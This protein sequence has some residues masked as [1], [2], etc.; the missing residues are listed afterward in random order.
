MKSAF[1]NH[2]KTKFPELYNQPILLACSGGIDSVVLAYLCREAHLDFALA[3]CNFKLR[4][5][6]SAADAI[7]V[8]QL[9]NQL[10]IPFFTTS[11]DTELHAKKQKCSIQM[12]ARALRYD[13]F[14]QLIKDSAYSYLLTAHH[15]DDTLETMLINLS[16]GTGIDGLLGI[17]DKRDYIRRPLLPFSRQEVAAYAAA[18][19]I[20]WREDSSNE[21]T[22]YLRNK[23]R[24]ELLP[25]FASLHNTA[26]DNM[27]QTQTY[28]SQTADL[29]ELYIQSLKKELWQDGDDG[30]EISIPLLLSKPAIEASL[31]ALFSP[32]GF[33]NPAAIL[34]ICEGESGKK[35]VSH[36]H[37]LLKDRDVLYLCTQER[38]LDQYDQYEIHESSEA[39]SHPIYLELTSSDKAT[40]VNHKT[41]ISVDREL[42]SYPLLLR[43]MKEGDVFYP[44]GMTGKK[45]LS[46]FLRDEKINVIS[47]AAIWVLTDAQD[48]IIWVVGM[49]ADRRF[50]THSKTKQY[51]CLKSMP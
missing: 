33:S 30:I 25:V 40:A 31:F 17:P 13:W 24:H 19:K 18:H 48:Q 21:E 20:D 49:R 39:I 8:K 51:L 37:V 44:S 29:S 34:G 42:L 11:F 22:K 26:L 32:F 4:G 45:R 3:H 10:S 12:A 23:I 15:R 43:H 41:H 50:Q 9:A 5:A 16:R 36:T 1:E 38:T 28:L 6:A 2:L 46:K 27:V 14:D 7:F 35:L 47:K